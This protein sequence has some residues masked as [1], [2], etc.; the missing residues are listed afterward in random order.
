MDQNAD[1]LLCHEVI[2]NLERSCLRNLNV[3]LV[4]HYD[5]TV[6][7]DPAVA[8][9]KAK[10]AAILRQYDP[11]L[12]FHDFRMVSGTGHTNL[13]FDI[14]LPPRLRSHEKQIL[15]LLEQELNQDP[16][17]TYYT[18]VTFDCNAFNME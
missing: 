6:T 3:N 12:S 13:I 5:P 9:A 17:H 11:E 8:A 14:V 10:V 18:V 2:D 7:D 16:N 1:P 15:A 4:L